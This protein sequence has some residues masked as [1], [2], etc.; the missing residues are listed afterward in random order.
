MFGL[1]ATWIIPG[2]YSNQG[3]FIQFFIMFSWAG[4]SVCEIVWIELTARVVNC[5]C[6]IIH[7]HDATET[8]PYSGETKLNL[9]S[10]WSGL[11]A[12][13]QT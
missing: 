12:G 3:K 10:S 11:Q 2:D 13:T 4:S 1:L 7:D 5:A 8:Q 9:L 6:D